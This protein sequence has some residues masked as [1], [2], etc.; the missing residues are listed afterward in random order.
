MALVRTAI[1]V[2]MAS[3]ALLLVPETAIAAP[4]TASLHLTLPLEEAIFS[5]LP[6]GD[7]RIAAALSFAVNGAGQFYNRQEAKGWWC[8][9]PLLAYP[10]AWALDTALGGATFRMT[11]AL[12]MVGTKVY[13]T[14]DAYQE[15]EKETKK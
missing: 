5:P 13:S 6:S 10:A 3:I 11:D 12:V 4:A 1:L 8:M 14:W 9:A 2:L 15:A 7:P